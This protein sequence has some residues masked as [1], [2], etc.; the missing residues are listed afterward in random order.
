MS[1]AQKVQEAAQKRGVPEQAHVDELMLRF[2]E[3][4]KLEKRVRPLNVVCVDWLCCLLCVAWVAARGLK[5]YGY[6]FMQP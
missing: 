2:Q 1:M 3:L 5:A 6:F 4:W